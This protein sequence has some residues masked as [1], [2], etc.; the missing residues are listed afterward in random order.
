MT[1][2]TTSDSADYDSPELID[3]GIRTAP[4]KR[5]IREIPAYE[6]FPTFQLQALVELEGVGHRHGRHLRNLEAPIRHG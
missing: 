3:D 2:A 5:I 4:S 6:G 1:L